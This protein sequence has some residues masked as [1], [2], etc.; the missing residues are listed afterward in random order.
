V[1]PVLRRLS[2]LVLVVSVALLG[3]SAEFARDAASPQPAAA[4]CQPAGFSRLDGGHIRMPAGAQPGSTR[5]LL[6]I[7]SGADGDADDNLK[8]GA[9][10]N[11]QGVAVLYP[12]ERA[13]SIWQLNDAMGDS[14]VLAVS[15][16]LER[17]LGT[18]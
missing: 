11:H 9:A 4:T 18:G 16:L 6:A 17:A 12:T 8:L 15:G 13:G 5:L 10:A 3:T 1:P 14:D 7:M 2:L